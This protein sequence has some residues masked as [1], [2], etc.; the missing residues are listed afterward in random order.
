M[1]AFLTLAAPAGAQATKTTA[2]KPAV[3][4][5]APTIHTGTNATT[6]AATTHA[7]V[8]GSAHNPVV[9]PKTNVKA[10]PGGSVQTTKNGGEIARNQQGRVTAYRAP[11][12]H[13]VHYD[14]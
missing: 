13:E 7:N 4:T 12:G 6:H 3:K 8:T 2:P 9:A 14:A 1:S 5:V 10:P 11:N